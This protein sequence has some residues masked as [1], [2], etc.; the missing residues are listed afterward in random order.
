[1]QLG[2][3][4]DP[5]SCLLAYKIMDDE[6]WHGLS[7]RPIADL[8]EVLGDFLV[9]DFGFSATATNSLGLPYEYDGTNQS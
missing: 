3:Y 4:A 9:E 2:Q 1:M 5:D 8:D 6:A 7:H